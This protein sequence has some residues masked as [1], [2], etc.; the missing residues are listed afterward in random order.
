MTKQRLT[1][2]LK[3]PIDYLTTRPWC[4]KVN[5]IRILTTCETIPIKRQFTKTKNIK[6]LIR[7]SKKYI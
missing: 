5:N 6:R 4:D 3:I 1:K 7:T 2:D